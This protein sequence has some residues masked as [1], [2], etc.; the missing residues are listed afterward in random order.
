MTMRGRFLL[1]LALLSIGLVSPLYAQSCPA[2]KDAKAGFVVERGERQK[3]E[4]FQG[5]HGIVRTVMRYGGNTLLETTEFEGVFS[6]ERLDRGRKTTLTPHGDLAKLFPLKP[7]RQVRAEFDYVDSAGRS[8]PDVIVLAVTSGEPVFIGSCKYD[9]LKIDW[10]EGRN[11]AEP[12]HLH[13]DYYSPELK[14][15]IMREYRDSGGR[16]SFIKYDRIYL[17]KN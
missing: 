3:S 15:V 7:N 17:L 14:L 6:L 12:H 5:D 13:T 2:A 16:S 11:G 8:T 1:S 9:V 4:V 10:Q